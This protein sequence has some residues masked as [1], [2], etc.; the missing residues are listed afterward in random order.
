MTPNVTVLALGGASWARLGSD[1]A[2]APFLASRGVELAPFQA[3]NAGLRVDWSAP[4]ERV[5]GMPVKGVALHAGDAMS[6]GEFVISRRGLEGGGI[7]AISRQVRDGAPLFLDLV[8]DRSVADVAAR[9]ARPRGK[10]TIVNV[11]RKALRLSPAQT[12]LLMEF[13]RPLPDGLTLA[14]LVKRCPS[15]T[16]VCDPWTRRSRPPVAFAGTRSIRD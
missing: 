3:A 16:R 15:A 9:L 5:F 2:W 13:G 6:R 1:G 7:Y 14:R 8:P 10:A 12:A 4:M 11:L